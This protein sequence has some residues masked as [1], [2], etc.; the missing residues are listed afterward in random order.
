MTTGLP[1]SFASKSADT[2]WY[3]FAVEYVDWKWPSASGNNRKNIAK[4]MTAATV[5]L[6][7]SSPKQFQAV[8]VRTALREWAFNTK[9]RS[10]APDDVREILD[11]VQRN[12]HSMAAWEDTE[13]VEAVVAAVGQRLDGA[14]A[15]AS[16]VTRYGRI[17]NLVMGYAIKHGILLANPLPKGKGT[18]TAPKVAQ[19]IDKRALLNPMQ[20]AL[21]LAWIGARPRRGRVYR[22]FFATIYYAALRPE[23][24]VALKVSDATLPDPLCQNRSSQAYWMIH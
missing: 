23:E 4:A 19:A 2:N 22:A 18:G 13:K 7:R 21:L 17:L 10:E 11:W 1:I 20:V 9:R 16:S 15:A 6:L 14:A 12:T 3:D 24:V 8:Q 5:A